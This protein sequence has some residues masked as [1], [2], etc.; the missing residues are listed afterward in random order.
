MTLSI[1]FLLV[2]FNIIQDKEY[3]LNLL[4]LLKEKKMQETAV[5]IKKITEMILKKKI[6]VFNLLKSFS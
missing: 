2:F 6:K 1:C 5:Q 4:Q 3:C